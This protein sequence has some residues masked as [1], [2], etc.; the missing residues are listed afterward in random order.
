MGNGAARI[1]RRRTEE[2]L[3]KEGYPHAVSVGWMAQQRRHQEMETWCRENAHH[4]WRFTWQGVR[5]AD[6]EDA[7]LFS[8]VWC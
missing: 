3:L 4:P 2:R 5:F 8:L 7:V 1:A 6:R